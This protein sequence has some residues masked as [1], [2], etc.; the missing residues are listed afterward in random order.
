MSVLHGDDGIGG[1]LDSR[2]VGQRL[3][4]F[5][6]GCNVLRA[7]EAQHSVGAG[8]G[9][10]HHGAPVL[11][12]QHEKRTQRVLDLVALFGQQ[13]KIAFNRLGNGVAGRLGA[14]RCGNKA[15]LCSDAVRCL[16]VGNLDVGD[17]RRLEQGDDLRRSCVLGRDDQ[18][19]IGRQHAL[20]GQRAHVADVLLL[21]QRLGWK[22]AR[23]VDR[24]DFPVGLERIEDLRDI[25]TDGKDARGVSNLDLA[26]IGAGNHLLRLRARRA[27]VE[28]CCD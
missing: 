15:D 24:D 8:M 2:L 7:G 25:A 26:S 1:E 13:G 23:R 5:G 21:F 16:V 28:Q 11:H 14:N 19:R 20:G 12:A 9:S 10:G 18:R 22:L 4:A 17:S 27:Q 3:V 6:K